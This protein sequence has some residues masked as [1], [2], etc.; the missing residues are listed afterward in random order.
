ML[1]ETW[2]I[3]LTIT[4]SPSLA[5][6]RGPGKRP[7]TLTMLFVV[8]SLVTLCFTIYR[9]NKNVVSFNDVRKKKKG[10]KSSL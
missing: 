1:L 2:L 7:F 6:I 8:H 4:R 9:H 3:T 5:I 10:K